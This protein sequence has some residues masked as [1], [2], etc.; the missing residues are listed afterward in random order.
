MKAGAQAVKF[1]GGR[2]VAEQVALLTASGVPVV[3]HL[4]FTPQSV[5]AF[6]G[7]RVQARDEAG[8][9][10]LLS[11]AAALQAAGASAVVL[12]MVPA[13]VAAQVTAELR[14]PTIGIGA[15]NACD[16]Q[17]LVWT[18]MAGLDEWAPSFARRFGNLRANLTE[19]ATAYA[20]AV[21]D[22]TYPDE[23]HSF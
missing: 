16:G 23:S 11:D 3:G 20:S 5:N 8:A 1:E 4:G 18:D 7:N 21:R 17:V 19:A 22:G 12:E 10:D 14:I 2:R 9:H 6:G 13:S 15:G